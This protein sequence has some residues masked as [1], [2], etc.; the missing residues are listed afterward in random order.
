MCI[1]VYIYVCVCAYI[2]I[3]DIFSYSLFQAHCSFQIFPLSFPERSF[4]CTYFIVHIVSICLFWILQ[5]LQ[6]I[7]SSPRPCI[8]FRN[9]VVCYGEELLAPRPTPNLEDDPLSAT[10]NCLIKI[11]AYTFNIW[12]PCPPIPNTSTRHAAVTGTHTTWLCPALF[13]LCFRPTY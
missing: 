8:I 12:G 5:P 3:Y 1:C 2:Y 9:K 4:N 6:V 11:F 13:Y 7:V 10:R